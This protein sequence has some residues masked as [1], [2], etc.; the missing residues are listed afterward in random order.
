MEPVAPR[1]GT[2]ANQKASAAAGPAAWAVKVPVSDGS[3]LGDGLVH[4]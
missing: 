1:S 3:L 2:R 4:V